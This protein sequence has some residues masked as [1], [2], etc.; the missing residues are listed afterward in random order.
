MIKILEKYRKRIKGVLV[1]N[2]DGLGFA[3]HYK[4]LEIC[5]DYTMNVFNSFAVDFL[6]DENVKSFTHS[7][8]SDFR[9]IE[10]INLYSEIKNECI[11]YGK[12][13]LI[14]SRNCPLSLISGCVDEKQC[15]NCNIYENTCMS[16]RKGMKIKMERKNGITKIFNP[17]ALYMLDR[18][19]EF[20]GKGIDF[21]RVEIDDETDID[22]ISGIITG[23]LQDIIK[24]EYY[25]R[26]FYYKN[27]S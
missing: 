19:E 12:L 8:E 21:L 4:D 5:T 7:I 27:I 10:S 14:T 15:R 20:K 26:G 2:I 22:Y 18:I 1:D 3:S 11:V 24:P 16:D 25:T 6:K 23:G 17:S 9:N 13:P